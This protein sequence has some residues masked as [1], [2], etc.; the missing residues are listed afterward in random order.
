MNKIIFLFFI[1]ICGLNVKAE[2]IKIAPYFQS[3]MV[4]QQNK[5]I[6]IWGKAP[7]GTEIQ[8]SF[9]NEEAV[10]IANKDGDWELKFSPQKAS[11]DAK[12]LKI[13]KTIFDN[14]LIGELWL[15]SGQSNMAW[16]TSKCDSTT[17]S[18]N[19]EGYK[20]I[21]LLTY[22]GIRG[23]AKDGYTQTELDRCNKNDFFRYQW[24]EASF[25]KLQAFSG[26][27]THFGIHLYEK[28]NVPIGLV[29]CA[30]GGSAIN[31]W[32]PEKVLKKHPLTQSL[33]KSDWLSNESV[34]TNHRKR[35]KSAFKNILSKNDTLIP[36]RFPYRFICEPDFAYEASIAQLGKI[37]FKGVLW[38]QGESDAYNDNVV[39]E[40]ES[41]FRLMV[42]SW[43]TNF[44]DH[45]LPFIVIQLPGFNSPYWPAMRKVQNKLSKQLPYTYLVS[46]IDLGD[47]KEIH[48]KGKKA[49]GER[50]AKVALNGVYQVSDIVF[51]EMS[52]FELKG[53]TISIYFKQ[54]G[55]GFLLDQKSINGFELAGQNGKYVS[56]QAKITGCDE[57]QIY[58]QI[59]NPVSL[60]YASQPFSKLPLNL[61]N[62]FDLPVVPFDLQLRKTPIFSSLSAYKPGVILSKLIDRSQDDWNYYL[63]TSFDAQRVQAH[64]RAPLP[65]EEKNPDLFYSIADRFDSLGINTY[66]RHIKG[67]DEGAWWPSKFDKVEDR[68]STENN[69]AK[70]IIDNAHRHGKKIIAYHRH[71]EDA[72]WAEQHPD[73][74]CKN[75]DGTDIVLDRPKPRKK[76]C[77]NSPYAKAYLERA[78]ELIALGVE[79]FYFDEIHQPKTGC[80]CVYC[81]NLFEKETGLPMPT[82]NKAS[83]T[84][85][86]ALIEYKNIIIERTFRWYKYEFRRINPEFV[87][88]LGSNSWPSMAED[89]TSNHLYRIADIH[90]TEYSLPLRVMKN[91][92]MKFACPAQYFS[93]SDTK[94]MAHGWVLARDATDGRPP[95]V[96]TH[97]LQ[98]EEAT[99]AA[100]AALIGHGCIANLDQ[101]E[102]E[103]PNFMFKS[104]FELGTKVSP[105]MAGTKPFRHVAIHYPELSRQL[106]STSEE[107]WKQV[108]LPHYESYAMLMEHHMPVSILTDSQ[109]EDGLTDGY[110]V[111]ILSGEQ[112]LT[113]KMKDKIV[114]FKALGGKVID[115]AV[116]NWHSA[117]ARIQ[118]K[119]KLY[120]QLSIIPSSLSIV[121]AKENIQVDYFTKDSGNTLI[122]N[123]INDFSWVWT[124]VSDRLTIEQRT[125]IKAKKQL[126]ECKGISIRIKATQQ[127]IEPRVFDAVTGKVLDIKK[128]KNNYIIDVPDFKYLSSIVISFANN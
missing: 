128:D 77:F 90:K 7:S 104:A 48:Y 21:R 40:Y 65:L 42:K 36:G 55:K 20:N 66:T 121:G 117:E 86:Q 28:L 92:K 50:S 80:W 101:K 19:K 31:S 124:G 27:G 39:K 59:K 44:E 100:T 18:I 120:D 60:R 110:K 56:V 10:C 118:N 6:T 58:S 67:A 94:K 30:I 74:V 88:I 8:A 126:K 5:L 46:T 43:R 79:G 91:R 93:E 102:T 113:T 34:F 122:V 62:S 83:D 23:V 16:P 24:Q 109:L 116:Y 14:I 13:G 11:F 82:S 73:W 25:K 96:W 112:Y 57:V 54:V 2:N 76:L 22:S 97:G 35:C 33:Y 95:H 29:C 41:L 81:Q 69:I 89:H 49:V 71:M 72:Y 106:F 70:R 45:N 37:K 105:V 4:L 125:Q 115:A 51:P 9:D 111:L 108:L 114:E 52:R 63:N 87:M 103:I 17:Q 123:C 61:K 53:D 84:L 47:E 26:V 78:K 75:L 99:L 15:C 3:G 38:Y 119:T 32:I 68:V 107:A 85:Y 98:S 12:E 127:L 64:T 1:L